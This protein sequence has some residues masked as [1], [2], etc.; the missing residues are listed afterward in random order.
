VPGSGKR[1]TLVEGAWADI[2][3]YDL[4]KLAIKPMEI[5][6]DFPGADRNRVVTLG[7]LYSAPVAAGVRPL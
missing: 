1:G 4:N 6:H 2:V 5:V 3:V 7:L